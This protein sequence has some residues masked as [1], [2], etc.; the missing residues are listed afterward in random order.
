VIA[1]TY[2]P[3]DRFVYVGGLSAVAVCS[4]VIIGHIVSAQH[5]LV[6]RTLALRPLVWIGSRSYRMYLFHIPIF[7]AIA[8]TRLGEQS[9]RLVIPLQIALTMLAAATSYRWVELYFL[10]RNRLKGVPPHVQRAP[11]DRQS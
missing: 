1:F 4:A 2:E 5:L 10:R 3:N 9:A 8:T 7:T 6:T 11:I